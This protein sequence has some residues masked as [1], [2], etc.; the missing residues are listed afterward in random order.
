MEISITIDKEYMITPL[1]NLVQE[2]NRITSFGEAVTLEIVTLKPETKP[3][4]QV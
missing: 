1:E 4:A 3:L 2:S